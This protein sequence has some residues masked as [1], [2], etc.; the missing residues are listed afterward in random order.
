M[1]CTATCLVFPQNLNESRHLDSVELH[2]M[3]P[4][5]S[6][7]PEEQGK[8]VSKEEDK[9]GMQSLSWSS[10]SLQN[11]GPGKGEDVLPKGQ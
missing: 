2:L 4:V 3:S 9:E 10:D 11:S 5:L 8:E 6:S 7:V 1:T